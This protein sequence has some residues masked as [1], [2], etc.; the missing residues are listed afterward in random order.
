MSRGYEMAAPAF[1]RHLRSIRQ[2]YGDQV[3]INL[4]GS[5]EGERMLAQ[6]FLVS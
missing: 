4:L 1:D 2:Q 6:A 5:K 3:I